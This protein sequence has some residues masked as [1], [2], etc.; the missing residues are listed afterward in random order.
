MA[1]AQAHWIERVSASFEPSMVHQELRADPVLSL[2]VSSGFQF[3]FLRSGSRE[4]FDKRSC[5]RYMVFWA[6]KA[7]CRVLP[8]LL[9][10]L[11]KLQSKQAGE[12]NPKCTSQEWSQGRS[13]FENE[14][15]RTGI[16]LALGIGISPWRG[17][18]GNLWPDWRCYRSVSG[19]G[20][21]EEVNR[22]KLERKGIGLSFLLSSIQ[23]RHNEKSALPYGF[24]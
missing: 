7:K 13:T 20:D 9:P 2:V 4:T 18:F 3:P 6:Q 14:R 11:G 21:W 8:H 19:F 12:L 17:R 15:A 22:A 23:M 1:K 24:Q 5:V 16:Q 10:F